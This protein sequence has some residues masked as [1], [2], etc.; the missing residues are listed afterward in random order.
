M[1]LPLAFF[2]VPFPS[3]AGMVKGGEEQ[4]R[5]IELRGIGFQ[6]DKQYRSCLRTRGS[7]AA[8]CCPVRALRLPMI[9]AKTHMLSQ[10]S[11]SAAQCLLTLEVLR[12]NYTPS[13]RL[14]LSPAG[15]QIRRGRVQ[16]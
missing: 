6:N 5:S 14:F 3:M 13:A 10:G 1:G 2:H 11:T 8:V 16:K 15:G 12:D 9:L 7:G 4:M